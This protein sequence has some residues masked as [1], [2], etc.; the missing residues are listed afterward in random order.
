MDASTTLTPKMGKQE[1]EKRV[2]LG[3]VD[4][5]IKTGKPVGSNTLKEAGFGSLSSA[6]IRNYFAALEE[7]G[8]L[9]QQHASGGR[10]PTDKAF[11][12]YAST[13][14]DDPS[15]PFTD[16]LDDLSLLQDIETRAIAA[17]LQKSAEQLA[18]VTR[19]AVFLSAP[20]FEHDFITGIKL[21]L[22]DPGRA[23][24]IM[25]TDF[26]EIITQIL[27][28]D[29]KLTLF[30]I[31]RLESYF[32]W[33]LKGKEKP[34]AMSTQEEKLAQELYNEL[35]VRYI[36]N[37]TNFQDN[38][39]YRTGFSTLLAY[40]EYRDPTVLANT[41]SLF[42]NFHGLRMLLTECEKLN[43]LKFWIGSELAG[44]AQNSNPSCSV[45]S[46][47]YYVN[48]YPAGAIGLLGPTRM[49]YRPLFG[50]LRH[51]SA[52]I[53]KTLTNNLYKFK[54]ALRPSKP[55]TFASQQS[56]MQLI[57]ETHRLLL[58]HKSATASR[59]KST[60]RHRRKES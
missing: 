53:S 52:I 55:S 1:R 26:G 27:H 54:I 23:I 44:H 33:R 48:N 42:E 60:E 5:Y 49:P 12:L 7:D 11:H 24:A 31:K 10:I 28:V 4:F 15:P 6:T 40:P 57:G 43:T 17:Y 34:E 37:Y 29:V 30:M 20:R 25:T 38:D 35:L 13:Y 3:L 41:F 2:L 16:A 39:L 19:S 47:P 56:G 36:V 21:V 8:Y 59:G 58:E 9:S 22:V 14:K 18:R 51:F 50:M 45:I 32:N 46:I